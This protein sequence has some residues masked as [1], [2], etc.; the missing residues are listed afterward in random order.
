ML[1]FVRLTVEINIVMG[2]RCLPQR[3]NGQLGYSSSHACRLVSV[4]GL[5]W[6][7]SKLWCPRLR[8]TRAHLFATFRGHKS[9]GTLNGKVQ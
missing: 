9:V 1:E 7:L 3:S 5:S 4:L 2:P 6:F 8:V